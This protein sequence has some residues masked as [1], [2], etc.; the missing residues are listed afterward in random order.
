MPRN[1]SMQRM[2]YA[3]PLMLSVS[4]QILGACSALLEII[5]G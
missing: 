3:P 2:G 4:W 1:N 5:R